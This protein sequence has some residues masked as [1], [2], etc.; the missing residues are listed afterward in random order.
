MGRMTRAGVILVEDESV[1]AIER[2]RAGYRYHLL[3]GGQVEPGE[4]VAAA[5]AREAAEELGVG[6]HVEG[7][8]AIVH[9]R[10][11]EQHYF[12]ARSVSGTFGTGDGPEMG[13]PV[14]S[15]AGSYRAVWLP[16]DSL[17]ASD[18]RPPPLAE[19]LEEDAAFSSWRALLAAPLVI[20]EQPSPLKLK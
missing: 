6:V 16:T 15:A 10:D 3:P 9:I 13:S 18:L 4:E 8:V 5:A 12:L 1:A 2:I 11:T 14:D 19:R 17:L 7:L 20:Y